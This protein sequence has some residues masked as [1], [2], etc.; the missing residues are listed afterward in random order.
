MKVFLEAMV[1]QY[2]WGSGADVSVSEADR[3]LLASL[4][5]VYK[6]Q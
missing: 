2:Y 3:S 4:H 1:K 5:F 6:P